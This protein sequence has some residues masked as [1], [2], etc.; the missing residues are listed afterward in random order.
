LDCIPVASAS[1][2]VVAES[3]HWSHPH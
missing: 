2:A 1:A 3:T